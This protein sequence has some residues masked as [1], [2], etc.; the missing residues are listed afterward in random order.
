MLEGV[1][2]HTSHISI[3][4]DMSL[5]SCVADVLA[6]CQKMGKTGMV[7]EQQVMNIDDINSTLK[8]QMGFTEKR[9]SSLKPTLELMTWIRDRYAKALVEMK[10]KVETGDTGGKSKK[11]MEDTILELKENEAKVGE[12]IIDIRRKLSIPEGAYAS[13]KAL[14]QIRQKAAQLSE[15]VADIERMSRPA[16]QAL[17]EKPSTLPE[18][19][20]TQGAQGGAEQLEQLAAYIRELK[21]QEGTSGRQLVVIGGANDGGVAVHL[22]S[23]VFAEECSNRLATGA[24]VEE[25]AVQN[26]KVLFEK[27]DGEGPCCGWVSPLLN[28]SPL[29]VEES[30]T[31]LE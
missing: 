23:E 14:R 18:S 5:S 21:Q 13:E 8:W 25:I 24:R 27:I 31:E 22:G 17:L 30:Q 2:N 10:R 1:M 9:K 6:W 28:G 20:K 12:L 7:M 15:T 26:G 29:L 4:C 19:L 11:E 16:H 3:K